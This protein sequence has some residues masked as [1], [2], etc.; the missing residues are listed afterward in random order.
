MSR[1]ENK[2]NA[3]V[4]A[5]AG[6][7]IAPFLT[8]R[9]AALG[10]TGL[11]ISRGRPPAQPQLHDAFP[12]RPLDLATLPDDLI[13]AGAVFISLAPI[14]TLGLAASHFG[15][16][17]QIIAFSSTSRLVK[18]DSSDAAE[19]ALATALAD[20]EDALIRNCSRLAVP[21]T[22]LR[23]TLVYGCGRDANITAM[24]RFIKRFGFFPVA[25]PA[26]GRRQPVHADDLA[27][28]AVAAI[29][30]PRAA[31]AAFNL[32]GG[33]TL[34]YREMARRVAQ[35]L[36]QQ[37]RLLPLPLSLLRGLYPLI[38]PVLNERYS[39]ALFARMNKDQAFDASDA[40]CALNYAP[41]PF[42]ELGFV[43]AR[44]ATAAP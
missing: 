8:Q 24:A 13:P 14:W 41:R 37:P 4:I 22:I 40:A 36:G 12:W 42:T 28:A 11:A 39:V 44:D 38:R 3:V 15:R 21:W 33:E 16:A 29:D 18:I 2:P 34:E 27:A 9:L 25:R 31:N 32:P 30:N 5:G 35:L 19:R 20:G 23:P 17:R 7:Q 10:Y 43:D 1:V 6:S 26:N